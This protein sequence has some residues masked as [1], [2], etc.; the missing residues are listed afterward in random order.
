M[1][2]L[3]KLTIAVVGLIELLTGE[4]LLYCRPHAMIW[5][6]SSL[7]DFLTSP[8]Y[9]LICLAPIG[10]VLVTILGCWIVRTV[11]CEAQQSGR[12]ASSSRT[13]TPLLLDPID[14]SPA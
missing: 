6:R 2:H 14:R 13:L 9:A 1:M 4:F 3:E 12:A 11:L 7:F 10:G 8:S 5:H